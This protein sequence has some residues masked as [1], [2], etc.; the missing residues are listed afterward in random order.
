LFGCTRRPTHLHGAGA[1]GD[2]GGEVAVAEE[3]VDTDERHVVELADRGLPSRELS[4]HNRSGG[5]AELALLTE[6]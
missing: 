3:G 2:A 6:W 4:W 1:A 5:G